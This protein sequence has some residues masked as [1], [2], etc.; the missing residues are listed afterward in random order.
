MS[1]LEPKDVCNVLYESPIG[2]ELRRAKANQRDRITVAFGSFEMAL[3]G[4]HALRDMAAIRGKWKDL[5]AIGVIC[6]LRSKQMYGDAYLML[7]E[8]EHLRTIVPAP[9]RE[10]E[11]GRGASE[12]VGEGAQ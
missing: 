9:A 5:I 6:P 4:Q 1:T 7:S 2:D 3:R 8:Y 11:G 10:W 12:R